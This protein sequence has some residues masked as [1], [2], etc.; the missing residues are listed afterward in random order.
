MSQ[1]VADFVLQR[2]SERGIHRI[3]GDLGIQSGLPGRG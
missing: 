3:S 1:L 2:V